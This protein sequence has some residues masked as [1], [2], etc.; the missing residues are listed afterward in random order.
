[1]S[2]FSPTP[3]VA[4]AAAS[5]LDD[6]PSGPSV[7]EVRANFDERAHAK[8]TLKGVTL[9]LVSL[10]PYLL[11][12]IGFA[13]LEGWWWKI[14]SAALVTACIPVLF[15]IGHDACHQALTPK[16]W[17]NKII[18]R[19][20]MLP[21]WHAYAVWDYGH[22]GLHHGWT[23]LRTRDHVWIPLTKDEYD[24]LPS[25]RQWLERSYR[26]WWGVGMYYFVVMWLV[27]GMIRAKVKN[28]AR[29]RLFWADRFSV[30]AFAITQVV[31]ALVLTN[32]TGL[33]SN[34]LLVGAALVMLSVIGPFIAWNWLMGF[35][36]FQHHTHP[37]V[38]WYGNEDDWSF[39]AGQVQSV[40]HIEM[41]RPI[42]LV[43][44]NIM[45]H[46]AHHVD[47]RIPLYNLENAQKD[48]EEAYGADL[49]VF[50]FT[51]RGYLNTLK[52]CRLFDYENFRWLDWNGTPT[53]EAL[54]CR[55]ES[56]GKVV[57][58]VYAEAIP[59]S[60]ALI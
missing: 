55:E 30:L 57:R 12:Y 19:V 26:T 32:R 16:S 25:Y 38:P 39:Y 59:S 58:T 20:A 14:A 29:N 28:V 4:P 42:E 43:L 40:V 34:S 11:G 3:E 33:G 18:G 46:T 48:L 2:V 15:V 52:T 60:P 5:T 50:P 54:L 36:I 53:T 24:A 44:H 27:F 8:S 47:T 49:V 6:V 22:N 17:L 23:N 7:R 45:E 56:H 10:V 51:I 41:P 31:V 9:F 21:S 35:L 13:V 37:K 1:M